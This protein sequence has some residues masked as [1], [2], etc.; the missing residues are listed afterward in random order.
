ML[1]FNVL[2][3]NFNFLSSLNDFINNLNDKKVVD[4]GISKIYVYARAENIEKL[5]KN[6][7]N[8]LKQ[9]SYNF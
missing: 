7:D 8:Y 6:R 3:S 1:T 4:Y 9:N 5:K 2:D